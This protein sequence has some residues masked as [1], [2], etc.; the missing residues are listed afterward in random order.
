MKSTDR[1][2]FLSFQQGELN[3]V[4]MYRKFADITKNS[5]FRDAY[6]EAAKDEGR[7]AA[8]ISGYTGETLKPKPFQANALGILYRILP[9][10]IIHFG[11]AQGEYAGGNGYKP[12]IGEEYPEIEGL[13]K[14]EY[15]HGDRFRN[16]S[17]R[18]K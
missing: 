14:D 2:K 3:A 13:M 1:K 5:A 10:K 11:I 15:K 4:L 6:L 8:V 17:K 9:K 12:Y 16:L 18:R 7:H